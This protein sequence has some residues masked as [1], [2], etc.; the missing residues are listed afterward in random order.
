MSRLPEPGE[1]WNDRYEIRSVLGR[2][3]FGRVYRAWDPL[4]ERDV[5]IKMLR[6]SEDFTPTDHQRFRR[7]TNIAASLEHRNIVT[8]YDGG[9]HRGLLY[10]V[11][12][13]VAGRDLRFELEEGRVTPR[14]AASIV[15]QVG[16]A[17]DHAHGK[18]LVHRDVKPGNILCQADSDAVFLA[19]FG[20]SRRVDQT[21][22]NPVTQGLAPATLAYAAPE[23]MRTDTRVDARADIYAL[24]CVLFECLTGTKPYDGA[25]A[26][27]INAHLHES[28]PRPSER[29][30]SLSRTWDRVI[31][32]AMAKDPRQRFQRCSALV[33]AVAFAA[34]SE[35]DGAAATGAAPATHL[36]STGNLP[37]G[38]A[39]STPGDAAAPSS[40]PRTRYLDRG[41]APPRRADPSP[42]PAADGGPDTARWAPAAID[43]ATP[44]SGAPPTSPPPSASAEPDA[45]RPRTGEAPPTNTPG[46]APARGGASAGS[47]RHG[48]RTGLAAIGTVVA[49]VLVWF[50]WPLLS[51]GDGGDDG[52]GDDAAVSDDDAGGGALDDAQ[53]ALLGSV[54]T[55]DPADCR[56][57]TREPLAGQEVAVAC[58]SAAQTP[59]Q[60]VFRRF[61]TAAERDAALAGLAG[62]VDGGDCRDDRRAAHAYTGA[63]GGGRVVCAVSSTL[64]GLSWSVPDEPV[65]GSA[66]LDD[67]ERADELYAWWDD[68]V[69]RQD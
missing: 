3:G 34:P 49:A 60:A 62:G 32:T 1:T 46:Q 61:G 13:F 4:L 17:L 47:G 57:P 29:D 45:A 16:D 8:V 52:G 2:G 38:G 40:R 69:G 50:A 12:R 39:A 30:S 51:P 42:G 28:P 54:G 66:R 24:G 41:D 56:P 44:G 20:I 27:M 48:R 64:A 21:T 5:A 53:L 14:R 18:G 65:M 35:P 15:R 11:M 59:T 36:P 19:D 23:Q 68:L 22:D 63:D 37:A 67:P 58:A 7:E 9:E 43:D 10:L 33:A 31:A 26:A 25:M 55:Y 6:L